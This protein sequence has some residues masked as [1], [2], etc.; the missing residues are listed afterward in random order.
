MSLILIRF[1]FLAVLIFFIQS[2]REAPREKFWITFAEKKQSTPKSIF[3]S[4]RTLRRRLKS[5]PPDRIVDTHDTPVSAEFVD[6]I[7]DFGV[8]L[9]QQSRWLNAV[10]VL[11][12]SE[13]LLRISRLPFVQSV[14]KVRKGEINRLVSVPH[15]SFSLATPSYGASFKQNAMINTPAAHALGYVGTGVIIGMIDT[16]FNLGHVALRN[17]KVLR[18]KDFV[19]GDTIVTENT[20]GKSSSS[21]GTYVLSVIAGHAENSLI[22]TAYDAS[23]LLARTEDDDGIGARIEEDNW[24][25][26]LEWL[27]ANGADVVNSSISFFDEFQNSVDRY[28]LKDLDGKTARTTIAT[29]IAYSKGLLV[30][31]SAGNMGQRGPRYLGTPSDGKHMI[32]VGAAAGDSMAI[33]ESSYGPTADGRKK[34]DVVALGYNVRV[35]GNDSTGY[36]NFAGTSLSAPLVTGL[37]ALVIQAHPRWPVERIYTSILQTAHLHKRPTDREG[38]GFPD[39]IKA[40]N[41]DTPNNG[42]AEVRDLQSFPNPSNGMVTITFRSI[43]QG[44]YSLSIYNTLGQKVITLASSEPVAENQSIAKRWD[45]R[46]W[47]GREAGSGIYFYRIVLNGRPAVE[48]IMIVK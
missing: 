38:R 28:G 36:D 20:E 26:A 30:V 9:I 43:V 22:G 16:G 23:F 40:I 42:T 44:T 15:A 7:S 48:K 17:V 10:S 11:A 18:T 12:S 21:H 25:A 41:F 27:E 47:R 4:E 37:A 24:I 46:D 31:N 8:D 5:L 32:A 35:V 1:V 14:E 33:V 29:D 3:L 34:P 6:Q 19:D 45:L 13:D 39:A 2:G